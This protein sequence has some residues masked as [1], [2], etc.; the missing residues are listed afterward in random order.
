MD[1]P[2]RL[3]L[4]QVQDVCQRLADLGWEDLLAHH[5]LD[6]KSDDLASELSKRLPDINRDAPGFEDCALE[7][8]RAIEPGNP[9]HSLLFHAFSS[10]QVTTDHQ[11]HPTEEYPTPSDLD[12]I[13]NYIYG[14][15]PPTIEDL[16]VRADDAP[17][18]IVVFASEYRPAISTVHQK[19]ADKVFARAGFTRVGT[20]A[21]KYLPPAGGSLPV[22]DHDE[23]AIRVLPC[24]YAPYIAMQVC[25]EKDN[26]GPL[27]FI[28][29][30]PQNMG[31]APQ[32]SDD[33]RLFWVTLHK[34]CS[35]SE[36]L[37]GRT[38]TDDLTAFHVNQKIRRVHLALLAQGYDTGW[39][40]PDIS[41][42]PFQFSDG[43]AG[44]SMDA[45]DGAGLL[46][47]W[48]KPAL[49]ETVIYK[50]EPLTF[51]VP[52]NAK[53][54]SSSLNI[55]PR[56]SGT[57]SA[58]E[59]V[60][61][62]HVITNDGQERNLNDE[63]NVAALVA[64]GGYRARHYRDF[65][66][67]GWIRATCKDLALEIPRTVAAYSMIAP[68]DYFPIV[69]QQDIIDWWTQSAP[70]ELGQTI[71][72][73][74]PGPPK[75]LCDDRYPGNLTFEGSVFDPADDTITSV[76]SFPG[77][78]ADAPCRVNPTRAPRVVTLPDGAAGIFAPGWD[79]SIDRTPEKDPNDD[80][81]VILP[82]VTFLA[83]YG[84]GCP[85]PEDAKLCAALSSFWPAFAPD[86]TRVFEPG[87]YATT[88]PLTDEIIGQTGAPPW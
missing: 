43:L 61:A 20:A 10:S 72:P 8:Y 16:R 75:A 65:T 80:G 25:G 45:E 79:C 13:E 58:P 50:G 7:G 3:L 71:W 21:C 53:T 23:N 4:S 55:A 32:I 44:F 73:N 56:E 85:F 5:G 66:G 27:R 14:V 81:K 76:V 9:A 64:A 35:G 77:A 28:D 22:V 40:E 11:G 12:I 84:L 70:P 19:H 63:P 41:E 60:H 42:S 29:S 36:C 39:A 46:I 15:A 6:I 68:P 30:V 18:A 31:A 52:K 51:K 88:T 67:D 26:F 24:R 87:K 57:R 86:N 34:I 38:I 17:L 82:G 59:Y 74:N 54:F 1:K 49:V 69:K 33:K 83:A 78:G 48:V 47:P 2:D 37:R 62:R